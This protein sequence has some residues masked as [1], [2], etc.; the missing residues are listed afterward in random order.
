[1]GELILRRKMSRKHEI[2]LFYD[3]RWVHLASFTVKIESKPQKNTGGGKRSGRLE[4]WAAKN[5]RA[6]S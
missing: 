3:S 2:W 1:M 6:E 5:E 4:R